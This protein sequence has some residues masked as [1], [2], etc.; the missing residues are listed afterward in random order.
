MSPVSSISARLYRRTGREESSNLL[1]EPIDLDFEPRP[2]I[3]LHIIVLACISSYGGARVA[4]TSEDK[5]SSN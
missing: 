1:S 2:R 3:P 5:S 4:H